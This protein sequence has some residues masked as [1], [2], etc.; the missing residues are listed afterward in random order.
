MYGNP[1]GNNLAKIYLISMLIVFPKT[2]LYVDDYV[3]LYTIWKYVIGGNM[4]HLINHKSL[5]EHGNNPGSI[6]ESSGNH[7]GSMVMM[8]ISKFG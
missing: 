5:W 3:D 6:C 1:Y 2:I 8:N 4:N 7:M